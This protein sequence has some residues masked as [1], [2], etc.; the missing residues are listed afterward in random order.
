MNSSK[1][2]LTDYPLPQRPFKTGEPCT[3]DHITGAGAQWLS[4]QTVQP[5]LNLDSRNRYRFSLSKYWQNMAPHA[6]AIEAPGTFFYAGPDGANPN[7]ID[8]FYRHCLAKRFPAIDQSLFPL[9]NFSFEIFSF[10]GCDSFSFFRTIG[11]IKILRKYITLPSLV[12]KSASSSLLSPH[13]PSLLSPVQYPAADGPN[14]Q[15]YRT[16]FSSGCWE[17]PCCGA[18]SAMFPC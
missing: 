3:P 6:A 7:S 14:I 13:T 11:R 5:V 9:P 18:W 16:V 17:S 15:E 4:Q 12:E 2:I 8:I 1:W 10:F